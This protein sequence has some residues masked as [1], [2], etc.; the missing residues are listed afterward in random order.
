MEELKPVGLKVRE[1]EGFLPSPHS[2]YVDWE[3]LAGLKTDKK[4]KEIVTPEPE[5]LQYTSFEAFHEYILTVLRTYAAVLGE[6]GAIPKF[7][8]DELVEK[9]RRKYVSWRSASDWEDKLGHDI[10][11]VVAASQEV[12][13]PKSRRYAYLA[14]T[15]NDSISTAYSLALRDVCYEV[16]TPKGIEF[17]RTM[18]NRTKELMAENNEPTIIIGRT[19]LQHAAPTTAEHW[20]MEKLGEVMPPLT[21]QLDHA[22]NLRGKISGFVGTRAAQHFLFR[23]FIAAKDLEKE[24]LK[25]MH[26]SPDPLTGQIVHQSYYM[27]YFTNMIDLASGIANF[28]DT[29]RH[30]QQTELGEIFEQELSERVGSS[31][32]AHKRNPVDSEHVVSNYRTLMGDVTRAYLDYISEFQRTLT[33][34]AN[35]RF[36]IPEIPFLAYNML[37][38]GTKIA[39]NMTI[40]RDRMAQNLG[41]T[42][43]LILGEPLQLALQYFTAGKGLDIDTHDHVRKLSSKALEEEKPFIEIMEQDDLTKQLLEELDPE[44]KE[45]LLDPKKYIGN[46]VEDVKEIVAEWEKQLNELEERIK[47]HNETVKY[48]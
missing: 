32:G 33:D 11:G 25:R 35:K 6:Y 9:L 4:T 1:I 19:H 18:L 17:G 29:I 22:D 42:Q 3:A 45:M 47:K 8:A 2:R 27:P 37:R 5:T 7:A 31:T 21:S 14:L 38:R 12:I 41:I 44:N 16:I 26:L 34:S 48:I 28:A 46:V 40:R 15:S 10:R 13:S 30:F 20:L 43:G 23:K 39:K 36:Y 24:T